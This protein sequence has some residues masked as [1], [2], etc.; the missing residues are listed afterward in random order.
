MKGAATFA[1]IAAII[2]ILV[3]SNPWLFA[4][5]GIGTKYLSFGRHCVGRVSHGAGQFR[6]YI[7]VRL[8]LKV[9]SE[10]V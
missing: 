10:R 4:G 9:V 7:M 6:E 3:I 5:P 2:V 1:A 8:R